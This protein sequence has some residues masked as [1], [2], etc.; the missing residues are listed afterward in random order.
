MMINP[1]G[2][3][4][5]DFETNY[6]IDRNLQTSLQI[7]DDSAEDF[8]PLEDPFLSKIPADLDGDSLSLTVKKELE[9]QDTVSTIGE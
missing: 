8:P 5:D 7:V 1:F 2:E 3:D 4:A 9:R 6:L